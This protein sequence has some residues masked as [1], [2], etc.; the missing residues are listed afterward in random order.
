MLEVAKSII[1]E[2]LKMIVM[3]GMMRVAMRVVMMEWYKRECVGEGIMLI[4][5]SIKMESSECKMIR[6]MIYNVGNK[7][8][9]IWIIM[10]KRAAE[11]I[12]EKK[13]EKSVSVRYNEVRNR[14]ENKRE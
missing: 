6:W 14:K 5:K 8:E 11:R 3:V 12:M 4:I 2:M 13:R 9:M 10:I 1:Y 7:I